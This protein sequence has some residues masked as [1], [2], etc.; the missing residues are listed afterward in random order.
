[1]GNFFFRS[2]VMPIT[3]HKTKKQQL[4]APEID[5]NFFYL[6]TLVSQA[7]KAIEDLKAAA[8]VVHDIDEEKQVAQVSIGKENHRLLSMNLAAKLDGS[9]QGL[10]FQGIWDQNRAYNKDDLVTWAGN[11]YVC[12]CTSQGASLEDRK[13]W[14][15]LVRWNARGSWQSHQEYEPGDLVHHEEKSYICLMPC[16][17]ADHG[18]ASQNWRHF[19]LFESGPDI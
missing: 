13:V 5:E 16:K 10:R 8:L 1:M 11:A 2:V 3:Y 4:T 17:G 18:P 7:I 9:G 14:Q 15:P 12:V 6:E 19:P